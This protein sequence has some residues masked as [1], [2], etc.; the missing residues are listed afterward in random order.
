[1]D[2]CLFCKII[3]G[4]I[5]AKK[6]YEDDDVLA[7]HDIRPVAKVHFLIIPKKHMAS[8]AEASAADQALLG[9]MLLLAAQL[10][11]EQGL[12]DGFKTSINTGIGG[13]QEVFHLH[14]HVYGG[15]RV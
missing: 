6:L 9:K 15:G 12:D 1:M 7:F 14:I 13:G 8:L 10:A 2:N 4:Q 5:P 3:A 11:K